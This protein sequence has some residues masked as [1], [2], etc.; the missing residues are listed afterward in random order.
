LLDTF[1]PTGV[2]NDMGIH[3]FKEKNLKELQ[4]EFWAQH[5]EEEMDENDPEINN[6]NTV[7]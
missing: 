3:L 1:E 4:D 6:N 7:S 5:E 2:F